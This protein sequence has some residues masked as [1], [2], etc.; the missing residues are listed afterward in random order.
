MSQI[1]VAA[2]F[3]LVRPTSCK[4]TQQMLN[5]SHPD[6]EERDRGFACRGFHLDAGFTHL[7][8]EASVF[9]FSQIRLA[10]I[11]LFSIISWRLWNPCLLFAR[12]VWRI[13]LYEDAAEGWDRGINI[14][15]VRC[16]MLVPVG[17]SSRNVFDI[18]SSLAS[19][20]SLN[21]RWR[22]ESSPV[23]S[24]SR[25]CTTK[26]WLWTVQRSYGGGKFMS[27]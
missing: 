21:F 24:A 3:R 13:R 2:V 27:L 15:C 4:R 7:E 11:V 9:C 5:P 26:R 12:R 16:L 8:F 23:N 19:H 22:L 6:L 14:K 18:F 20:P 25:F 17:S 1:H 10:Y